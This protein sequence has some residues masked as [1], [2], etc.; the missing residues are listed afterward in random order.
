MPAKQGE[1][2]SLANPPC[3]SYASKF[4][5][6]RCCSGLFGQDGSC[7]HVAAGFKPVLVGRSGFGL[8]GHDSVRRLMGARVRLAKVMLVGLN[9]FG[10][11]RRDSGMAAVAWARLTEILHSGWR[12]LGFVWP[13]GGEATGTRRIP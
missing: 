6:L 7:A 4:T 1:P 3:T 8:F 2:A 9:S 5:A 11:V 10:F 12:R 13:H